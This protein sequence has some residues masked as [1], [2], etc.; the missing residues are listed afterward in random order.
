MV[1]Q[2]MTFPSTPQEGKHLFEQFTLFSQL[3]CLGHVIRE[4]LAL[5][6]QKNMRCLVEVS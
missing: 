4:D 5:V 2:K 6:K 3:L 1:V